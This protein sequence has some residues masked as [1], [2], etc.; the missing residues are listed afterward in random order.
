MDIIDEPITSAYT[1]IKEYDPLK[2]YLIIASIV[3]LIILMIIFLIKRNR[4]EDLDY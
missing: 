4:D 3:L 2:V 1:I